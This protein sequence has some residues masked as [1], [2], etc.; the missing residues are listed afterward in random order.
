MNWLQFGRL[1]H[2]IYGGGSELPDLEW[3]QRLGL[4]AVKLGQVHALRID[5]LDREKCEHLAK[6]YRQN[7]PLPTE[8][9]N[10]LLRRNG[11]DS[12]PRAFESISPDALATASVGQVH[13]GRL[14]GGEVVVV[15]VLKADVRSQFEAD[16][17]SLK[18]LF[19]V[20][21]ILYPP[22]RRVGDPIGILEDIQELTTTELDL[23]NEIAGRNRLASIQQKRAGEFDL[24][25]L[26]FVHVYEELSN[27]NVLVSEFIDAPSLDEL[28]DHGTLDYSQLLE[29][30]RIHGF[31]MF[32][33]GVFHGDLHP[34]N[35]LM[36]ENGFYFIDT[37]YIG[38]VGDQLRRGLFG[39]FEALTRYDYASCA[40]A[41]HSMSGVR[42]GAAAFDIFERNFR[43]LYADFRGTTVSQ[44]SLTTKMMQ[45]IRLGVRSGMSFERGMFGIIRSLMYLDGM[46]LRC[47]PEAVLLED[48]RPPV[49][50]M[51]D[52]FG[53][54]VP[55]A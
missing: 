34:G 52:A 32:V 33:E 8:D 41:L 18:R 25:K 53:G 19:R 24:S 40:S 36:S 13:R 51:L 38:T 29:L 39:F 15:K 1:I 26:H 46:V 45:T 5:F 22:L 9:F 31:Y 44:V 21:S 11:I 43:D 48:M 28:L 49:E 10:D 4:L 37:A 16:I 55:E 35:V 42:L 6:L 23:G 27:R 50:E 54:L 47:N 7:R 20:A 12:L 17:A 3:I 14:R 30:F 2:S